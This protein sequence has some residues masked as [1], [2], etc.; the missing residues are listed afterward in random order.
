MIHWNAF[1]GRE[2]HSRPERHLDSKAPHLVRL[3]RCEINLSKSWMGRLASRSSAELMSGVVRIRLLLWDHTR[4]LRAR[5]SPSTLECDFPWTMPVLSGLSHRPTFA[6]APRPL[7]PHP[8][9]P[10]RPLAA[11]RPAPRS[12][13]PS[14]P[15]RP[16][17]PAPAAPRPPPARPARP[18]A[19]RPAH[20]PRPARPRTRPAR[21][22]RSPRRA[23]PAAPR[24]RARRSRWSRSCIDRAD[25]AVRMARLLRPCNVCHGLLPGVSC[26][27]E[28]IPRLLHSFP[29]ANAKATHD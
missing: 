27:F 5:R 26:S 20:P 7:A 25:S 8:S 23:R 15:A 21:P 29:A 4:Q 18:P 12:P 10:A 17:D 13:H 2:A 24:T 14:G 19:A 9:G 6:A 22:A 16:P 28:V 11:P 1:V 3:R